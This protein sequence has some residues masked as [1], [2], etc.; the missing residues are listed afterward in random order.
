[1]N[2]RKSVDLAPTFYFYDLETSGIS[3]HKDRVMQFAGMRT[4]LQLEP[5]GEPDN[6]LIKLT[7]D[8]L[9]DPDAVLITGITPQMTAQEGL[10]E[11]DF[12]KYFHQNIVQ[13]NTIF[14]GYNSI[15]FDDEFMRTLHYRNLYDPYAWQWKDGVSRWDLLDVVRMVRALRPEGIEWP[16]SE[17]GK[18]TNR[19][20]LLTKSNDIA[21][22][23]AHDAL[24]DVG[25]TIA[26]ARL[27]QTKKSKLFDY[28]LN[29]R[30]KQSVRSILQ[31]H[32]PFVYT[33]GRYAHELKTTVAASLMPHP[34]QQDSVFVYDLAIDP[35]KICSLKEAEFIDWWQ[36]PFEQQIAMPI[37]QLRY[38]RCPAL[39]P[40]SVLLPETEK[41]LQLTKKMALHHYQILVQQKQKLCG[42]LLAALGHDAPQK[43]KSESAMQPHSKFATTEED[44][45]QQIY[46]GFIRD[47]EDLMLLEKIRTAPEAL[48]KTLESLRFDD[49][50]LKELTFRYKARHFS[51]LLT[52]SEQERWQVQIKHKLVGSDTDNL[53]QKYFK[54]IDE[55]VQQHQVD[56]NKQYLLAELKLYGENIAA[57]ILY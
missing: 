13:P 45:D 5:I 2:A 33:S 24:S 1:M 50:R 56:A 47:K 37:K 20:E 14:V 15:R 7:A 55:L 10:T 32:Q 25:A 51:D 31:Q 29:H 38:N 16:V 23:N 22:D 8:I 35:E 46:Q 53:L 36:N 6:E 39:A 30:T 19:L 48:L 42:F 41:R 4:N 54:R 17:E 43:Y 9:P 11:L 26:I 27:L 21:H 57:D 52:A 18:P 3:P 12:L 40:L 28:L 34:E 44:V 49:S